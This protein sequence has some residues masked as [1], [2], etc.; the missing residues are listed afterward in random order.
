MCLV[1]I[2][3]VVLKVVSINIIV[4]TGTGVASYYNII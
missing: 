1:S 2:D 4:A 3:C